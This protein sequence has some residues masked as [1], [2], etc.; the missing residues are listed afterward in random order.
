[1]SKRTVARA[2]IEARLAALISVPT[3]SADR[4]AHRDAFEILPETLRGLYPLVYQHLEREDLGGSGILLRWRG[5]SPAEPLILMAHW[6]VVPAPADWQASGW[7]HDPFG[8][9]IIDQDG[10]RW[11]VG[12]GALD[13]KGQIGRASCRERV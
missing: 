2:G 5:A 12:R 10:E 3:V 13:D 4:D 7:Q 6:D 11:V 9:D 1:M 8:G